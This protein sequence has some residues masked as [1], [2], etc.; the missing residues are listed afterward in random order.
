MPPPPAAA[1][2]PS[3]TRRAVSLSAAQNAAAL[4]AASAE[5]P[6]D[7]PISSSSGQQGTPQQQGSA[8]SPEK[9]SLKA[10]L[11]LFE[12]EIEQQ[13][14]APAKKTGESREGTFFGG[15][16]IQMHPCFCMLALREIF[17]L[18]DFF[19]KRSFPS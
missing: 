19:Q 3:A 9:L 5:R 8:E 13:G 18:F 16:L 15:V 7:L 17:F 2:A 6:Q 11:K 12:K 4:A 14:Q 10:R 1:A